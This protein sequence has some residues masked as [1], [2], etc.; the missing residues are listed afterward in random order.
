MN[1]LAERTPLLHTVA[2]HANC[3]VAVV[4]FYG[5]MHTERILIPVSD[6]EE[7]EYMFSIIAAFDA[8]GEHRLDLL[9]MMSSTA[10]Q[11]ET[12]ENTEILKNWI[13]GQTIRI[14]AKI[15]AVPTESRL[16]VIEMASKEADLI[17]MRVSESWFSAMQSPRTVIITGLSGAC[18]CWK[19][20]WPH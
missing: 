19:Q 8:V 18:I 14:K 4:R 15:R 9:Y 16:D 5:E 7:L 17:I 10:E 2:R 11:R 6:L 13:R 3:P 12:E 1:R 20:I